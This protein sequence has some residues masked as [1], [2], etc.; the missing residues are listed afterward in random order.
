MVGPS[1]M[2]H[3]VLMRVLTTSRVHAPRADGAK[4]LVHTINLSDLI[5]NMLVRTAR[6]RASH[7]QALAAAVCAVASAAEVPCWF[8]PAS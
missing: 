8:A 6:P 1:S 3:C 7:L 4:Y 5:L 2:S